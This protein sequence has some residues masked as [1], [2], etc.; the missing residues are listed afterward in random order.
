MI[1]MSPPSSSSGALGLPGQRSRKK[2]PSRN[3][4]GRIETSASSWIG[5]PSSST[6]NVTLARSPSRS[7]LVTSP[8]LT[9]AIRTGFDVRSV[10]AFSNV[11]VIS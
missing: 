4:R 2:L 7:T 6:V 9:P 3:S 10:V 5:W 8:T 11:A 1:G